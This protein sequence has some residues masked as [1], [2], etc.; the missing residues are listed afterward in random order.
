MPPPA[1][2][3]MQSIPLGKRSAA[4]YAQKME[5]TDMVKVGIIDPVKVTRSALKNAA[6]AASLLL[7]A[8]CTITD[9][10]EKEKPAMS[11]GG[12]MGGMD[13]GFPRYSG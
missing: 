4:T 1:I 6:S 9:L 5:W 7:T 2:A 11:G 12:G 13:Y 10:P 8:E 3:G